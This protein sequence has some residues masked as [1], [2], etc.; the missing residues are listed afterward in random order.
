MGFRLAVIARRQNR[1]DAQCVAS[2]RLI[3]DGNESFLEGARDSPLAERHAKDRVEPG[4]LAEQQA[5][6]RRV[7]TLVASGAPSAEVLSAVAQEVAQVMHLPMVGVYR[8]DSDGLMTVIATWSDRPHVL[9]PGTRWPL[10]GQSMVA[11]VQRS[12]RPARV[13]DYTDL[14][15]ALAAGARESGLNATAGAPII[16]NGSVCGAMGMSSPDAPLPEHAEDRLAEFTELVATAIANSQAHE[17]LTRLAEEQAA[18]RR[19][20]TLVAAGAPPAEVFDAV[21]AEV[22]ALIPADGS[23]LTRYEADGT[24]TPL[25]GWAI[26]GGHKYIGRHYERQGT[27]SGVIFETGRPGRVDNYAEAPGEALEAARELAWHSSVG[28]PITVEGR[29]WGALVVVTKSEQPLPPET[30]RRLAE[31]TELVATAIANSEA[32]QELA[33]LADEQAALRRVA[34]LAAQGVPPGEVFEAVSAEVAP[35]VG[36]DGAGITRYETDGT[37]TALGGWTSGGGYSYTGRRFPLEGSVSGLVLETR[38]TSRIDNFEG[39]P[40]EAAAAIREMGWRSAMGSPISVEGR[41]WGVLVV[42][43]TNE[44]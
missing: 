11:Q 5:A 3:V 31:F 38:R 12:G 32:H 18:L 16:V 29:L 22:A 21:S 37:F 17:E 34:T 19:V 1:C 28:A 4:R 14:P 20:A 15:G 25:S 24:F 7:A 39:R 10:D 8:Y 33:R 2:R 43:A 42:Y 44:Q 41:V 27:V 6:L 30:E 26:D 35:L 13:E 23:A 9:Q 40:G 36:A